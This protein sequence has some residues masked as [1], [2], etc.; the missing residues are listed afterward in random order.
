ML[1]KIAH[2]MHGSGLVLIV[3]V[4]VMFLAI[5]I[6]KEKRDERKRA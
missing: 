1:Y 2:G 6:T 3:T 5:M 4:T